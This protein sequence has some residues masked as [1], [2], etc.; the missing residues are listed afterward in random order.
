MRHYTD[1]TAKKEAA[2]E[3]L[4]QRPLYNVDFQ[5]AKEMLNRAFDSAFDA[6][7][8][9][10]FVFGGRYENLPEEVYKLTWGD[11]SVHRIPGLQKKVRA[12]K[13]ED[14]A[15]TAMVLLLND[16]EGAATTLA[17][18]KKDAIKGRKPS[19]TP[20]KTKI[21]TLDNTG[22]CPCC[23]RNVKL[24]Y[25]SRMVDHGFNLRYG[26]RNGNC[27]GVG[28]LPWE[29]SPQ[30]KIDFISALVAHRAEVAAAPVKDDRARRERDRMV[31]WITADIAYHQKLVL[32][33]TVQPLPGEK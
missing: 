31:E 18:A 25:D 16:W 27:F 33:W 5:R 3:I 20:R 7:V 23:G 6:E 9:D 30:G 19:D 11:W 12:C 29:V 32:G 22:T 24:R 17:A 1:Y 21:R 15:L 8:Q 10:L 13:A 28:K 14:P 26:F 2:L 4:V